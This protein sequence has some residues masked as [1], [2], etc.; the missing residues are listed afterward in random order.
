MAL[1]WDGSA[2][3][4]SYAT[5]A[6]EYYVD[7]FASLTGGTLLMEDF[8]TDD[9]DESRF[10]ATVVLPAFRIAT[11]ILGHRPNVTRHCTNRRYASPLW[12]AYPHWM[13][14]AFQGVMA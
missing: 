6:R 10:F 1:R 11:E 13:R 3:L 14:A 4:G 2:W 5:G 9:P 12:Y 8:V 7:L